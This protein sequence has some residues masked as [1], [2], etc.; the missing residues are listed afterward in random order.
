MTIE[1]AI[2]RAW[3]DADYKAKLLSDPHAALAEHGV[4]ISAGKT[5]KVVE[6]TDDTVHVVLPVA[7]AETGKVSM[8]ELEEIAGGT[9]GLGC[10]MSWAGSGQQS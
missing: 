6:N 1:K 8:D 9:G 3:T 7:P 2:A 5:V 10:R 4:K